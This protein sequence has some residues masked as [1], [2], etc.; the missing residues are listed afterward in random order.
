M[1]TMRDSL[2]EGVVFQ[3][4]LPAMASEDEAQVVNVPAAVNALAAKAAKKTKVKGKES[5]SGNPRF[6]DM[7]ID[8]ITT[9]K[10]RSG[11]S[12]GAIKNHLVKKFKVDMTKRAVT[13]NRVLKKM[14]EE[15]ILVAGAQPGRKGAGCYK[16]SQEEKIR[17][18]EA[19]KTAAKKL[20]AQQKEGLGKV[21]TK[22]SEKVEKGSAGKKSGKGGTAGKKISAKKTA[23][24][25][26]KPVAKSGKASGKKGMASAAKKVAPKTSKAMSGKAMKK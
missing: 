17:I 6:K 26:K 7:V 9:Q 11:S 14:R 16:V 23:L 19:A 25:V 15:G 3:S 8:A 20:K 22:A 2:F 12:L 10:E 13:L 5:S 1:G 18:A 21:A 4:L 24:G